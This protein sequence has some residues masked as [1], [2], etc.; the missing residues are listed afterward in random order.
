MKEY[1]LGDIKNFTWNKDN[2]LMLLSLIKCVIVSFYLAFQKY[3]FIHNDAHFGNI[4]IKETKKD[5]LIYENGIS[6]KLYGYLPI[7]MDFETSLMDETKSNYKVLHELLMQI[8]YGI[9]HYINIRVFN[10]EPI[11]Q[12][13]LTN[14]IIDINI[15]LF[16]IDKLEFIEKINMYE[17]PKYNPHIF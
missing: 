6:I 4:L 11:N 17:L 13:L 8:I 3:G 2:F 16:L 10:L 12:Y 14:H 5:E 1:K 7:I 9:R 15:L